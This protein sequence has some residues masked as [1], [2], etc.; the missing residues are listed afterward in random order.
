MVLVGAVVAGAAAVG[1]GGS[2]LPFGTAA[3]ARSVEVCVTTGRAAVVEA[4]TTA[5]GAVVGEGFDV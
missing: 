4:A 1:V 5:T 3:E 2:A